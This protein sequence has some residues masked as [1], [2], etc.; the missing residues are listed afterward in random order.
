[1]SREKPSNWF[2]T[3]SKEQPALICQKQLTPT[4]LSA[5]PRAACSYM[6]R[7]N[8]SN[9]FAT[10][11]K[12]QPTLICQTKSPT[13][14]L[15][16]EKNLRLLKLAKPNL[17]LAYYQEKRAFPADT[18]QKNPPT[19][20]KSIARSYLPKATPS[21]GS[22]PEAKSIAQ[23]STFACVPTVARNAT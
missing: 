8:H 6:S 12:E 1:M 5:V 9:W 23:H 15:P 10:R 3:R 21:N 22:S 18:C 17:Q 11:R 4:G 16:G 2:A 7:E 19:K 13:G 14:L 20:S